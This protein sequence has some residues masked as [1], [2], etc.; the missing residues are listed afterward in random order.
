MPETRPASTAGS[1]AFFR[2]LFHTPDYPDRGF[3]RAVGAMFA[4]GLFSRAVGLWALMDHPYAPGLPQRSWLRLG[5]GIFVGPMFK[6][7]A[8]GH[9]STDGGRVH[10][11]QVATPRTRR[12]HS[13]AA[14]RA[15]AERLLGQLDGEEYKAGNRRQ[16]DKC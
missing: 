15:R 1:L 8:W 10:K 2:R 4:V 3:Y 16:K 14:V 13:T 9:S 12:T 7:F 6:V 11:H 5:A